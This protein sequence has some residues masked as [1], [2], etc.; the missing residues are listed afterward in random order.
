MTASIGSDRGQYIGEQVLVD[1]FRCG[2]YRRIEVPLLRGPDQGRG[3]A[4]PLNGVLVGQKAH[5]GTAVLAHR[6]SPASCRTDLL[7]HHLGDARGGPPS[8]SNPSATAAALIT[9]TPRSSAS[10]RISVARLW[11][12]S[13]QCA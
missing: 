10:G 3:A 13:V 7:P 11:S 9:P 4:R 5:I 12:S 8:V 6:D 1:R 2:R